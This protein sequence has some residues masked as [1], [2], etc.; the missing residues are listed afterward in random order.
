MQV[1]KAATADLVRTITL[2]V[3]NRAPKHTALKPP[4]RATL[5]VINYDLNGDGDVDDEETIVADL[6]GDGTA[7]LAAYK[8]L[9][10]ALF[11][12]FQR[13]YGK[14]RLYQL[15]DGSTMLLTSTPISLTRMMVTS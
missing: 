4:K 3:A 8:L 1:R 9:H 6:D 12:D 10:L 2:D 5:E 11:T 7:D 13:K 15:M 14:I